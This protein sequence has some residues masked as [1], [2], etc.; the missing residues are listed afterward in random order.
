[1]KKSTLVVFLFGALAGN[2]FAEDVCRTPE[3]LKQAVAEKSPIATVTPLAKRQIPS[4]MRAFNAFPPATSI[5]ADD[6]EIVANPTT[7]TKTL[8]FFNKGCFV[9]FQQVGSQVFEKLMGVTS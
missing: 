8:F 4:V 7:N 9:A 2:A 1:M 3:M 6:V 5:V